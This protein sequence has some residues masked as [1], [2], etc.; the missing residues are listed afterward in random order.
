MI[1]SN[2][3][4]Q[5]ASLIAAI[6][7]L[8]VVAFLGTSVVSLMSTQTMTSFGETQSTQALYVAEGGSEFGQRA[9]AQNLNWYRSATDPIVTPATALGSGTFTVNTYL[10]A[11]L[12]RRRVTPASANIAVFTTNRFPTAGFLQLDDITGAGEFVQYTGVTANTFTG[13]TRDVTIGGVSAGA[14][15]AFARGTHVYPVTTLATALADLGAVC[16]PTS[17]AAFNIAFHTKNLSAGTITID[18]EDISYTGSNRAGGTTTLTGV[19]RCMNGTSSAHSV[20]D[21]VIP[22][23]NDGAAPDYEALL[24]ATGSVGAAP[25]GVAARVVQKTVQR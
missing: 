16:A 23:L 15:G 19:T 11:T 18:T 9:L 4:E 13:I 25:L 12:L 21:P 2:R 7:L 8:V 5:G 14:V 22:V 10:P 1:P 17:A 24:I 6:F 3:R 20:G